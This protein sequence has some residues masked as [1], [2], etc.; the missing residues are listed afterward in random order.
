MRS[1]DCPLAVIF[2]GKTDEQRLYGVTVV[3]PS[4]VVSEVVGAWQRG[5]AGKSHQTSQLASER[6][7]GATAPPW[8]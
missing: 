1:T 2:Y 3:S 4:Y 7:S 6:R 8:G 5:V